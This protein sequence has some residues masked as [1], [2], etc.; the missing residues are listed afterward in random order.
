MQNEIMISEKR[1]NFQHFA[2]KGKD[3]QNQL[4]SEVFF[5]LFSKV[6]EHMK[7]QPNHGEIGMDQLGN[8]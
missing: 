8:C 5:F 2:K 6:D 4:I 7:S 1:I 3:V